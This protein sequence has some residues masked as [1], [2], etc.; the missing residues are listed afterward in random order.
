MGVQSVFA[1]T[2]VV[3]GR[4]RKVS[5][6]DLSPL[7]LGVQSTPAGRSFS[8]RT[9]GPVVGSFPAL[10]AGCWQGNGA[11]CDLG[12][13]ESGDDLEAVRAR[14]FALQFPRH[15]PHPLSARRAS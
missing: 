8:V 12:I 5:S 15:S 4:K 7:P 9:R 13:S 6:R 11:V 14:E 3:P 10:S 2:V 1:F